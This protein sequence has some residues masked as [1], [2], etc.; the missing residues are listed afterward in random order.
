M[1]APQNTAGFAQ[2]Q[3]IPLFFESKGGRGGERKLS[4]PVKRKF[5][6]PPAQPAFTLIELLVVIAIIAILA[7]MLMPALSQARMKARTISCI[8]NLK[9]MGLGVANY[10]GDFSDYFPTSAPAEGLPTP[11]GEA[12]VPGWKLLLEGK[13]IPY[14]QLDCPAD[15]TKRVIEDYKPLSWMSYGGKWY[16]R[17]YCIETSLGQRS[18]SNYAAPMRFNRSKSPGRLVMIFC[19]DPYVNNPRSDQPSDFYYGID[20]YWG[21]M[22]VDSASGNKPRIL[23]S[24]A[25]HN[26]H[27]NILTA[28][29]RAQSYRILDSTSANWKEYYVYNAATANAKLGSWESRSLRNK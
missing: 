22:D 16:N 9:Q 29:G 12:Y 23:E 3:N 15:P 27:M 21:H 26:M 10:A 14:T 25:I 13:Y 6:F 24:L 11:T 20:T 7:A 8:N 2:Q 18:G 4:F 28:D 19:T 1:S 5:P 17:S